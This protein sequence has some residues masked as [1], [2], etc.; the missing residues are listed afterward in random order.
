VSAKAPTVLLADEQPSVRGRVKRILEYDGFV[1]CGETSDAGEAVETALR[2]RPDV[3]IIGL[4]ISGDPLIAISRITEELPGTAVIVLTVSQ[5]REN[6]VDAVRAG[7]TGYL[8]QEMNAERI[9]AAV[10]GV[11]SGEAAVPRTLVARLLTEVRTFGEGRSL[12]G[13][14]GQVELTRREWEVLNLLGARLS[15]AEIAKRLLLSQVT[16]RRHI[17]SIV[18]KLGVPDRGAAVELLDQQS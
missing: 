14:N 16:V 9:P 18:Q 7:A 2:E 15:T 6:L 11:L 1:I 10:R 5:S 4:R 13:E 3:C 17:S 12:L 8:L